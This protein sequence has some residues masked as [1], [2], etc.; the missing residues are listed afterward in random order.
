MTGVHDLRA[1]TGPAPG[2]VPNDLA[3]G[4]DWECR[5]CGARFAGVLLIAVLEM[6]LTP[7]EE[8]AEPRRVT[9]ETVRRHRRRQIPG[10]LLPDGEVWIG[11][12]PD[13]EDAEGEG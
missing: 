8:G 4:I 10:H 6:V 1:V 3:A 13:G 9:S 5:Q 11:T 12:P 2:E 7:C